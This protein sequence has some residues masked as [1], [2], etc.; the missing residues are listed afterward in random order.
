MAKRTI[1]HS[2]MQSFKDC[3]A[4]YNYRYLQRLV[5]VEKREALYFGSAVHAGLEAWFRYGIAEQAIDLA[6]SFDEIGLENQCKAAELLRAYIEHWHTEPFEVISIERIFEAPLINP[7]TKYPSTY[8]TLSGK[9]DGLVRYENSFYILEHKTTSSIDDAYL[10]RILIDAQ[11]AIYA[12]ALSRELGGPVVGAIYDILQKPSIRM[13]KGESEEEFE[14]RRAALIAKS[15]TGKSSA[16]QQIAET[17]AEFRERLKES[18]TADNF[19][20]E[21][22]KFQPEQLVQMEAELWELAADMRTVKTYYKNTSSC[23]KY[24]SPCEYLPLC[25]CNGDLAL[26]EGLYTSQEAHSELKCESK[27]QEELPW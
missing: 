9:V 6:Y 13:K 16:K 17:E 20:R 7:A 4:K 27:Q 2:A 10:G 5:P 18:I 11:I 8:W 14:A 15:K 26:C 21:I 19:R 22:V 12:L 24:G 25:R 23:T 3:R 1:T